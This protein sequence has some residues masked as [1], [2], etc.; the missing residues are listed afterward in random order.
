MPG[1]STTSDESGA[2]VPALNWL[3]TP[4]AAIN[5]AHQDARENAA[6]MADES[7]TRVNPRLSFKID[8]DE[9]RAVWHAISTTVSLMDQI[10]AEPGNSVPAHAPL[11]GWRDRLMEVSRRLDHEINEAERYARIKPRCTCPCGRGT[12]PGCAVCP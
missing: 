4:L 11:Y 7:G 9:A 2:G 3:G 12:D 5:A 6:Q 1:Q 8:A 10:E